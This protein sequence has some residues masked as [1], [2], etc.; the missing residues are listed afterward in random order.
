[1][2]KRKLTQ[3]LAILAVLVIL[4]FVLPYVGK[5]M[6]SQTP[7]GTPALTGTGPTL[8]LWV[9]DVGQ[10]DCIVAR[11]GEHAVLI[12]AGTNVD[13]EKLV[14]TLQDLD[15]T[16]FDVVIGTHPHE[17]HIGGMDAVLLAFPVDTFIMPKIAHDTKTF[18]DVLDAVEQRGLQVTTP[19]AGTSYKVGKAE[20]TLLYD[21]I[22]EDNLN[23]CSVVSRLV[24]AGRSILLTGDAETEVEQAL[25]DANI[26]IRSDFLKVGHHGSNTSSSP[27]FLNAVKPTAAFIS[28]GVDNSYNHPHATTITKLNNLCLNG[29]F[30]TDTQGTIK[31]TVQSDGSYQITTERGR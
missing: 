20:L 13:A 22:D 7:S 30:R 21:G 16:R 15:I 10:A 26:T 14:K 27:D 2:K 25:V 17:D 11:Q 8:E 24:Y 4:A 6:E 29:Y 31:L 18:R 23:N 28:C 1:M 3:T 5:W 19:K 9:L 12:D